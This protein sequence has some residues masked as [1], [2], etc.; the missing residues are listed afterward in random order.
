MQAVLSAAA[1][2]KA[3]SIDITGGAPEMHPHFRA[4][5]EAGVS[6]ALQV[7]V[8]TNLTIML[9][10]GYEDMPTWLA[11]RGVQLVASLPCYLPTNVDRQRGRH[12]YRDSIEVIKRLNAAG[13]GRDPGKPLDLV[14]NPGGPSLPP[15]QAALENDYR[16]ALRDEFGIEFRRL[17]TITNVPIGRFLADLADEGRDAEYLTALRNAFNADTL[18][19]LM[20]R[21]Q[22]HVGWDGR[23]YDCDFNFAVGL[24]AKVDAP[25]ISEF[26]SD[27][28]L[29]RQIA[30][31]QHC[32]ACTAG[33]GSSCG[34]SIVD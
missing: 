23:I 27:S 15:P 31:A 26:Q 33:S 2:A 21:H 18:S 25:H 9:Q 6:Q 32:F 22:L 3:H 16:A 8:R 4:F 14:Y 13:Y 7:I 34:G 19:G 17:Y 12:V 24:P 20:C 10:D 1:A 29:N 11:E 5:V 30:V 28:F